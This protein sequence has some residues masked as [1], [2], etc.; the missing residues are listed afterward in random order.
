M[1]HGP[2]AAPGDYLARLARLALR[3]RVDDL[4][5]AAV[6]AARNVVL[7]TVGAILAGSRLPENARLADLA[8]ERSSFRT[9]T[10]IGRAHKADPMLATLANGTAGVSLE[11]DEGNRWGGGHPAIHVLPAALAVAEELGADG[12]RL[13]EALVAGYEI[14]S[15]LGGAT[16]PRPNLHSHGTWGTAGAAVAVAR[17]LGHEAGELRTV[18]NL[19]TSMSPAN[20][21]GPCFEGATIRNLY[22]GRA[23]LQGILAVHLL[24]CG[25]T[26][27]ADAPADVYGTLLAEG[28]DPAAAVEAIGDDDCVSTFRIERNYFKFHA[29][30]LYNHPALDAVQALAREHGVSADAVERIAVTSIPFVTRMADPEPATMLGAKFSVPYAVAAALIKGTTDVSAFLDGARDDP[31]IRRLAARVE[32]RADPS[33]SLRSSQQPTAHVAVTLRDGRV[34]TR[35]TTVVHGDADNPRPREELVAKFIA[36]AADTLTSSHV[37]EVV[38]VVGRLERLKSIGELT[39]LLASGR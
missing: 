4:A 11:V 27:V 33:M 23:G 16:R 25:F 5:P 26:A 38:E 21:W 1:S 37:H 30:C 8:V 3:V 36:L 39:R 12:G 15:R 32:V 34:L 9:A 6:D 17:L 18:I 14:T 7:D 19:A 29:C 35:D 22:P 24:A 20:S 31:R 13:I 2:S 28:F 10:V